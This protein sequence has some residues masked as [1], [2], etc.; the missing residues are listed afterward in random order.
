MRVSVF[1]MLLALSLPACG[2]I[3]FQQRWDYYLVNGINDFYF[4]DLDGDKF[5]EI[6]GCSY[7]PA[8]P[9]LWVLDRHGNLAYSILIPRPGLV[10]F[11]TEEVVYMYPTDLNGDGILDI[12]STTEIISSGVNSHRLYRLERSFESDLQRYRTTMTWMY[13]R[14]GLVTRIV[15]M[16]SQTK[17]NTQ[18]IYWSAL[19][20]SVRSMDANGN[21]LKNVSLEGSVYDL[22]R[23]GFGNNSYGLIAASFGHLYCM[24]QSLNIKWD[25]PFSG[26]FTRVYAGDVDND[27]FDDIFAFSDGYLYR[28]SLNGTLLWRK[29]VGDLKTNIYSADFDK[30]GVYDIIMGVGQGVVG[31]SP[32][33]DL[34]WSFD[35]GETPN[36]VEAYDLSGEG[37]LSIIVAITKGLRVFDV[38][39]PVNESA[40]T[41]Y[42]ANAMLVFAR[43]YFDRG[44]YSLSLSYAAKAREGFSSIGESS[45]MAE[46]DS[47]IERVNWAIS[48]DQHYQNAL[49]DFDSKLYESAMN[50]TL[51]ALELYGR[52]GFG[53]DVEK[54]FKL[55]QS[56]FYE[57]YLRG[58][59][60]IA[61]ELYA[62]AEQYYINS[63]LQLAVEYARNASIYYNMSYDKSGLSKSEMLLTSALDKMPKE[64]TTTTM[65]GTTTTSLPKARRGYDDYLLVAGLMLML[66]ILFL[67]LRAIKSR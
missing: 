33:G 58:N 13:P 52:L 6:Y 20:L 53:N 9:T 43:E 16:E 8:R 17:N 64:T 26:R 10:D 5:V 60:T 32:N 51:V 25:Y 48:A 40:E 1:L 3:T 55:N 38:V 30:N 34:I 4:L 63:Q 21:L 46:C 61:D 37:D 59:L 42:S 36:H 19:D 62:K 7:E 14:T 28:F 18:E 41:F 67:A 31:L 65:R 23:V 44:N 29:S 57:M 27:T 47:L 12:L 22:C 45:Q 54:A 24:D 11:G 49:K 50:H 56:L 35:L 39:T 2:E 66:A 15:L